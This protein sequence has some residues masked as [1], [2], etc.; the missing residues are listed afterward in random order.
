MSLLTNMYA[1]VIT[2]V[3]NNHWHN[4][5]HNTKSVRQNY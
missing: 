3:N 5:C 1:F 2:V 4:H